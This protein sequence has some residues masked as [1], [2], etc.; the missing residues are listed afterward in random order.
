MIG[1]T[2]LSHHHT[3]MRT[4]A[5]EAKENSA[6]HSAKAPVNYS[7]GSR[8]SSEELTTVRAFRKKKAEVVEVSDSDDSESQ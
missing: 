2:G 1:R 3:T 7:A 5:Q 8:N 6:A 4:R